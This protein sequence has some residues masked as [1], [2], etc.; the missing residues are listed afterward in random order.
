MSTLFTSL[1]LSV[2]IG[3]TERS[4]V[5]VWTPTILFHSPMSLTYRTQTLLLKG[6]AGYLL[7]YI[8]GKG[9]RQNKIILSPK[10]TKHW[11]SRQRETGFIIPFILMML[12]NANEK[13]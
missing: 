6:N 3:R 5:T 10:K 4:E 8:G 1:V 12:W 13:E 7:T 9:D 2:P 11:R